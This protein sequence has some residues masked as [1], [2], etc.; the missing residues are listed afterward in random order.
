MATIIAR[1]YV[2]KEKKAICSTELGEIVNDIMKNYF[3]EIV[4]IRFTA[5]MEAE[6]DRVEDGSDE[7]KNVIREFYPMF[8]EQL[9]NAMEKL[10][11]IEIKDEES[12]VVCEKCGRKMVIKVGRYGKF[13]ACPG[14][15]ECN[16]A[17]PYYESADVDCPKCGGKVLKKKSKKGRTYYG[18][19]H[20][21][22]CDFVSWDKPAKEK[23][24]QCGAYMVEK[25][26]NPV[27]LVCS[28]QQCGFVTEKKEENKEEE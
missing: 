9:D 24:P 3:P 5:E 8:K 16:N 27:K 28:D 6:L 23:C 1:N 17:K 26:R 18:C 20:N 11:K 22:E 14:Y 25:G 21:P 4:N 13:L 12:D 10:E 2:T 7:W 19:E 15:P